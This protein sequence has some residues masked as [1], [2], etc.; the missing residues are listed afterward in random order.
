MSFR[1]KVLSYIALPSVVN[2]NIAKRAQQNIF[3]VFS[4]ESSFA[5]LASAI[6]VLSSSIYTN[7]LRRT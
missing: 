3:V 4:E 6:D 5:S 2:G 7:Y 1:F